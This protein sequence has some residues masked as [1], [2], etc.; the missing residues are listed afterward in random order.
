[1][2]VNRVGI[3]EVQHNVGSYVLL[4]PSNGPWVVTRA[5]SEVLGRVRE[6]LHQAGRDRE[7]P[8]HL[9]PTVRITT[10]PTVGGQSAGVPAAAQPAARAEIASTITAHESGHA[11]GHH[12]AFM[13]VVGAWDRRLTELHRTRATFADATPELAANRLYAAA[14]GSPISIG[15]EFRA[16]VVD[17][18]RDFHAHWYAAHGHASMDIAQISPDGTAITFILE[19]P[20]PGSRDLPAL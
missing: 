19:I 17:R 3:A 8:T 10:I 5:W 18:G 13:R 15:R 11:A 9:P 12:E 6:V 16:A 7:L 2:Q 14:G 4:T 1:M 20:P